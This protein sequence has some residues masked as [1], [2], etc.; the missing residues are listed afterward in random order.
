MSSNKPNCILSR[1]ISRTQFCQNQI[2]NK[3]ELE[4]PMSHLTSTVFNPVP[5][6]DLN[7]EL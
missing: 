6:T 3:D 7:F 4:L 1:I 2:V 5:T